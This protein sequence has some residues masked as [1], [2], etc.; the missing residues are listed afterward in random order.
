MLDPKY[1]Y[2]Y[3][4]YIRKV[5]SDKFVSCDIDAF[6]TTF[7]HLKQAQKDLDEL[8]TQKNQAAASKDIERG[9]I[10]KEKS[11]ACEEQVKKLQEE[12]KQLAETVPNLYSPDTPYGKDD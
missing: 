2:E 7:D 8:N 9:K 11:I 10:L 4:D 3:H 1:I 12:F 5:C 6:I